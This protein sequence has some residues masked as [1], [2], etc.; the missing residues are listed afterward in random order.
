M[1]DKYLTI[2]NFLCKYNDIDEE[3]IFKILK[4][5][6]CRYLLFLLLKKYDCDDKKT[7]N[8]FFPERSKR[9]FTYDFKKAEEKFLVNRDLR[10]KYFELETRLREMI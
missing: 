3:E 2:I 6:E 5:K 4:D 1:R 9:G 8:E 7:L 10:K